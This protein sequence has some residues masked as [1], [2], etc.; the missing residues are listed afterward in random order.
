MLLNIVTN[1]T[2]EKYMKDWRIKQFQKELKDI[3]ESKLQVENIDDVLYDNQISKKSKIKNLKCSVLFV[4]I[5]NSTY[6]T[7]DLGK[8]NMVKIYK[9][10]AKLVIKAV[11]EN[12]GKVA[13]I[14]GD[15]MLCIF[16]NKNELSGYNAVKASID[17]NLYLQNCYNAIVEDDWKI[18]CGI[19]I[20]TGHIYITRIGTRGKNKCSKVAYPS[21]ITNYACKFCNIA[22]GGQIILDNQTYEEI[23]DKK[24]K[25]KMTKFNHDKDSKL[26]NIKDKIWRIEYGK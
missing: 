8:K 17:I 4:D 10:F 16:T 18:Q 25:S 15:G 12:N 21:C 5:R 24:I 19:G 2:L 3:K 11:E 1:L 14:M 26:I 7:D 6:M 20:R 23:N 22:K 13:E 9:M